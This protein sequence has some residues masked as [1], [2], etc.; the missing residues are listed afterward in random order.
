M[1]DDR[2]E[3][4]GRDAQALQELLQPLVEAFEQ[5]DQIG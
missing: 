1:P 5:G 4:L 3:D 2:P